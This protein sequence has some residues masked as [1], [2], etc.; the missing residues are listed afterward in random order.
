MRTTVFAD[1]ERDS[2]LINKQNRCGVWEVF[3]KLV[4]ARQK[5]ERQKSMGLTTTAGMPTLAAIS[6]FLNPA[7]LD[8]SKILQI[9]IGD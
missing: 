2:I 6:C 8:R 1:L 7:A 3:E 5:K 9:I 4:H